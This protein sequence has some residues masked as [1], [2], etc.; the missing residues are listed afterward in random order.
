MDWM[1]RRTLLND[2]QFWRRYS[3]AKPSFGTL[4]SLVSPLLG[5][6]QVVDADVQLSIALRRLKGAKWADI[7]D[8]HGVGETT[9]RL[10]FDRVLHAIDASIP[11]VFDVE[12]EQALRALA[13]RFA[14]KS[15]GVLDSICGA[16]DGVQIKV[17]KPSQNGAMYY[18][19]KG[20][21]SVNAQCIAGP[22]RQI[23]SC[24]TVCVGASHDATAWAASAVGQDIAAGKM[25]AWAT[26]V[27]DDAYSASSSQIVTPFPGK[28][29]SEA[30]DA[31]NYWISNSRIEVCQTGSSEV[32]RCIAG[33]VD[34]HSVLL[35]VECAFGE[36]V[37]RWQ[38]LAAPLET[39]L[40]KSMLIFRVC[41][42][43]HN[44]CIRER[45]IWNDTYGGLPPTPPPAGPAAARVDGD[46]PR[47]RRQANAPQRERR[48]AWK[49]ALQ[50]AGLRRRV[51]QG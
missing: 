46:E 37:R 1:V 45:D 25:P 23:L 43:L 20:F 42:K 49:D 18:C 21:Y 39:D 50:A 44:F 30:Q 32:S 19:R 29:L 16:V 17:R 13:A 2:V 15:E 31:A 28:N 5:G 41:C 48:D 38:I 14:E 27:G 36:I 10:C 26:I 33:C 34:K 9:A 51:R 12:D 6:R 35:Q 40:A 22:D 3:M 11:M 7:E 47:G 8:I 4:S 24:S